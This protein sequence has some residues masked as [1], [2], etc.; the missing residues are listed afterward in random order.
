MYPHGV[1]SLQFTGP[2]LSFVVGDVWMK[3]KEGTWRRICGGSHRETDGRTE[4][5]YYEGVMVRTSAEE[6]KLNLR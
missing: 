5:K 3:G 6:E 2:V 1:D 4:E